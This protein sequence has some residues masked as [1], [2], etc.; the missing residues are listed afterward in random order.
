MQKVVIY[1][2]SASG[3]Q[4]LAE[5]LQ[6]VRDSLSPETEVAGVFSDRVQSSASERPGLQQAL[7]Y[8]EGHDADTLVVES[9]DRLTRNSRELLDLHSLLQDWE[10]EIRTLPR[11]TSFD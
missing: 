10:V 8:L 11:Q 4:D 9:L 7:D 1:I 6:N 3:E 5:Q 2:R